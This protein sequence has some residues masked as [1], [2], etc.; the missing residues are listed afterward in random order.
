MRW[1]MLWEIDNMIVLIRS[2]TKMDIFI[3]GNAREWI[4]K[5]DFECSLEKNFYENLSKLN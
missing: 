4:Y 1:K 5:K 2:L 3:L